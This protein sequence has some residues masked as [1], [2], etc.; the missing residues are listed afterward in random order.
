MIYPDFFDL[1]PDSLVIDS[2]LLCWGVEKSMFFILE[3]STDRNVGGSREHG[4]DVEVNCNFVSELASP[5]NNTEA[6][7]EHASPS[8]AIYT[9]AVCSNHLSI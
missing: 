5:A 3:N 9:C 8:P 7:C 4:S 6:T 1:L 2:F